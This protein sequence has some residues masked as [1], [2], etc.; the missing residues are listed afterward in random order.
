ML[1][2]LLLCHFGFSVDV[3]KIQM[4][5]LDDRYTTELA[6]QKTDEEAAKHQA[7]LDT[8]LEKYDKQFCEMI[9]GMITPSIYSNAELLPSVLGKLEVDF[10]MIMAN[11]FHGEY[12]LKH[13]KR[14]CSFV[15]ITHIAYFPTK[16]SNPNTL[17]LNKAKDLLKI[18]GPITKDLAK[19]IVQSTLSEIQPIRIK[20]DI[21]DSA[22]E[23]TINGIESSG[24]CD[25]LQV[26]SVSTSVKFTGGPFKCD[27][28][29]L[30]ASL[31]TTSY[32]VE[33]TFFILEK[34]QI[35]RFEWDLVKAKQFLAYIFSIDEGDALQI[36][37]MENSWV[38]WSY[39]SHN[40]NPTYYL[41]DSKVSEFSP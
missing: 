12:N 1:I 24:M 39:N 36:R 26:A 14:K 28:F 34:S 41:R 4:L 21:K 6:Q 40:S 8:C 13:L 32:P 18:H 9:Y 15:A 2:L 22:S 19:T 30:V 3:P 7:Q 17:L 37:Y 11:S 31:S 25:Y 23:C 16:S 27:T 10:L 38:V 35:P 33:C 20:A 29:F 5:I